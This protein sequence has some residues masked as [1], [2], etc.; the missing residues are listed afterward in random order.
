MNYGPLIFLAAFLAM[1]GSWFG[2][3]IT[4]Q[5]QVGRQQPTNTLGAPVTY[6]V[7]RPGLA[8]QGLQV[9]RANGCAECH[10]QQ[11]RQTGTRLE[12]RAG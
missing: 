7:S 9:Y 6:P 4:P 1:A 5:A 8:R 12:R 2:F 3:V 11:I 10:S